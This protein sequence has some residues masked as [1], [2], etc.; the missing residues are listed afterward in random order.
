MTWASLRGALQGLARRGPATRL[1]RVL[2]AEAACLR[3]GQIDRLIELEKAR[4]EALEALAADPRPVS[5]ADIA[6][7]RAAAARNQRL[8]RATGDGMRAA[9]ER[10]QTLQQTMAG[11]GHY[12]SDGRR[13]SERLDNR[14]ERKV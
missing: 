11:A 2:E 8:L 7:L 13:V 5:S 14:H 12:T 6:Q 1:Q 3:A 9:L 4:S 10:L